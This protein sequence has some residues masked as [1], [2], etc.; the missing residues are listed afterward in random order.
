MCQT[1]GHIRGATANCPTGHRQSDNQ[2][3]KTEN[4]KLCW[5]R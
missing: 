1:V 5:N 4:S 3:L 2:K